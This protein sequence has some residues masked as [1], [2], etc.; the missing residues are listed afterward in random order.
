M[1]DGKSAAGNGEIIAEA[2][3][4]TKSVSKTRAAN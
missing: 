4:L 2:V 3:H 1:P